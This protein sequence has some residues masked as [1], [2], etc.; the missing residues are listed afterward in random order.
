MGTT[1]TVVAGLTLLPGS[2]LTGQGK[3]ASDK[4]WEKEPLRIVELEEGYEFDKKFEFLKDLGANMEHV[5]RFTDTSPG[6]SFLDAHNLFGGKKVNFDS[7]RDYLSAAH[8]SK[9][10][11]IIYYNVHAIEISYARQ[12]REWQ[13]ILDDGK[14]IEDVY[15][16]DSSF[17]INSAWREEVFR[18]LRKLASYEIDGIFYDGPIFFSGT[19]HCESCKR[20]FNEKYKKELPSK[21]ELSSRHDTAEWKEIVEFQSDSIAIF[22]RESNKILKEINPQILFYMNGNTIAPSWPTGR[23]NRKIIRETDILGAE[24]WIFIW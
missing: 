1:G 3:V 16:V 6:T 23:D 24:G 15:S 8:K 21:A 7:L 2:L 22:L 18:T 14:P 17:C 11:V 9:I 20:L 19:C 10:R 12:H 4:W 5:T 13:Q